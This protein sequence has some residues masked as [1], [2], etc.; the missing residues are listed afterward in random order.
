MQFRHTLA[1]ILWVRPSSSVRKKESWFFSCSLWWKL[2]NGQ[3]LCLVQEEIL[4]QYAGQEQWIIQDLMRQVRHYRKVSHLAQS[5]PFWTSHIWK[6]SYKGSSH[7]LTKLCWISKQYP[8]IRSACL[9]IW[10]RSQVAAYALNVHATSQV[11]LRKHLPCW[12]RVLLL[13][14]NNLRMSSSAEVSTACKFDQL[15]LTRQLT[16]YCKITCLLAD[17]LGW[18]HNG[19]RTACGLCWGRNEGTSQEDEVREKNLETVW[20]CYCQALMWC[21]SVDTSGMQ[22]CQYFTIHSYIRRRK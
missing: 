11:I 14:A 5:L 6:H 21:S 8:P 15:D 20:D 13:S 18:T 7:S 22:E 16:L 19:V 9:H 12:V 2:W 4:K 1:V 10:C 17:G 3:S